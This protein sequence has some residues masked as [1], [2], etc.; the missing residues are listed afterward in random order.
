MWSLSMVTLSALYSQR[1]DVLSSLSI[2]STAS[3]IFN[4]IF[5]GFSTGIGVMI[6]HYLG[7]G[8]IKEAEDN[9]TKLLILAFSICIFPYF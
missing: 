7:E 2:S 8:K 5:V 4:I 9:A 1:G 3:E 6:G